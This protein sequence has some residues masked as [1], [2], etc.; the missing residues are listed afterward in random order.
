MSLIIREIVVIE[1]GSPISL[2]IKNSTHRTLTLRSS[3]TIARIVFS[4]S[5][6]DTRGQSNCGSLCTFQLSSQNSWRYLR[7]CCTVI[8]CLLYISISWQCISMKET[9]ISRTKI[10][11][12]Y[13]ECNWRNMLLVAIQLPYCYTRCYRPQDMKKKYQCCPFN[14]I[15]IS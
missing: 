13:V 5:S 15:N 4:V 2:F 3:S 8:I 9:C 7:M 14:P 10:E 12:H 11:L 1:I 6:I